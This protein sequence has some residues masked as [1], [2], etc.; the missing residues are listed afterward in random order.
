M[1]EYTAKQVM[2][3]ARAEVIEK[4]IV[5]GVD[6]A[7]VDSG[8]FVYEVVGIDGKTQFVE[9]KFVVKKA[10]YDLD[11]AIEFYEEKV[12]AAEK[13]L[14]DAEK[15]NPEKVKAAELKALAKK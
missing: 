13:R 7:Q 10:G 11:E 6:V 2:D 9:V 14:A 5:D 8:A 12:K 1:A 3:S 15:L 4:L